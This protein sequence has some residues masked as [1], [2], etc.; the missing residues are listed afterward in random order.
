MITWTKRLILT[1]SFM[2][3]ITTNILTLTSTAFNAAAS[4]LHFPQYCGHF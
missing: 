1:A 4:G 3:L 2:A